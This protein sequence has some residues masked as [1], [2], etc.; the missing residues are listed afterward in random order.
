[1]RLW[2]AY[3]LLAL[4]C[5]GAHAQDLG[6]RRVEARVTIASSASVYLDAG[7]DAG[8]EPGDRAR[9]FPS[10]GS[11]VDLIVRAVS[12]QSARCE[13]AGPPAQVEVGA[14]VEV[15][16]PDSRAIPVAPQH[17]P[18]TY[19]AEQWKADMPLLAPAES[20][21]AAERERVLSGR[22]YTG[23]DG[24]WEST[25]D[26]QTYM[27]ARTGLDATL[28]NA[29]GRGDTL[30]VDAE[31]FY[32]SNDDGNASEDSLSA[33]RVDRLSWILGD[34]R[35]TQNRFEVGRFLH[36]EM[37][38]LGLVDGA[39]YVRR[40]GSGD[41]FGLSAGLFPDWDAELE[42]GDD[43]QTSVFY[44]HV[45]DDDGE[46]SLGGALQKTWH[47]GEADRDLAL[48]DLSWRPSERWWVAASAWVDYYDSG[49]APKSS[50]FELTEL[51]AS[52]TW[53]PNDA[54]GLGLALSHVRWPVLLHDELPPTTAD[55]LADGRVERVGFNGWTDVSRHARLYGRFDW[56]EDQDGDGLGG[57]ARASWRDVLWEN[58]EVGAGLFAQDG[59][60]TSV[61]GLRLSASRWT[62]RGTWTLWYELAQNE[63]TDFGGNV[64]A[65]MQQ[66][67]R[68]TWDMSLGEHWSLSLGASMYYGDEQDATSLGFWLQRQF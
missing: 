24:T 64:D 12:R 13:F 3:L 63:P 44:R 14:L 33:L 65:L 51:H 20:L 28:D 40:T 4:A 54:S 32:R 34:S 1:M 35:E 36:S 23:F 16:V 30:R 15:A 8:I 57:E 10:A 22:W 67:V 52:T 49:D 47:K 11:P 68:G 50:G 2:T 6:M 26:Q 27:L 61:T 39:E 17:P 59:E 37:P 29:T 43:W 58:G 66:V 53:R 55:T 25:R 41:R 46:L 60:A 21:S 48:G 5:P 56:W 7:T 19:P 42:T 9:A 62:A 38:Q 45:G 18:W 31:L